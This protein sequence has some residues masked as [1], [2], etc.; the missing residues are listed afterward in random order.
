[1]RIDPKTII[2]A[3]DVIFRLGSISPSALVGLSVSFFSFGLRETGESKL[4]VRQSGRE[5]ST[6]R[7]ACR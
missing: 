3:H 1:M 6:I 2:L 7:L 5:L 4:T